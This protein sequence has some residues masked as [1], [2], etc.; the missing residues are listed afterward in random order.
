MQVAV[1]HPDQWPE[2]FPALDASSRF[3]R[4][5]PSVS[6]NCRRGLETRG[7]VTGLEAYAIPLARSKANFS[8]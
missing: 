3:Q 7:T 4:Q 1:I 6:A 8:Y 2:F 5:L